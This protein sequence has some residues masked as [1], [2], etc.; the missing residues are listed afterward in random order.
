MRKEQGFTLI[1]LLVVIAIIGLLSTLA[2]VSLSGARAK[3]RDAQRL[4]DVKQL[5]T[6]LEIDGASAGTSHDLVA[7]CNDADVKTS[8]CDEG[9]SYEFRAAN[10]QRLLDPSAGG[11]GTACHALLAG[12]DATCDYSISDGAGTGGASTDDYAICFYLESSSSLGAAGMYKI[13]EGGVITAD[14][15]PCPA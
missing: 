15:A 1:E 7:P 13:E 4:S 14:A 9:T 3:A 2:V 6:M 12:A 10:V 11:T 5:S 8:T